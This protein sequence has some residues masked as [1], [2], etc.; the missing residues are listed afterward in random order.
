MVPSEINH[1][2][3]AGAAQSIGVKAGL[4]ISQLIRQPVP[5]VARRFEIE[6][7]NAQIQDHWFT[8]G[9][10]TSSSLSAFHTLE[11]PAMGSRSLSVVDVRRHFLNHTLKEVSR[12]FC[13]FVIFIESNCL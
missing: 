3:V 12:A 11:D 7:L 9:Q 8:L 10:S 4:R 2:Q 6:F 13:K 5:I 1:H